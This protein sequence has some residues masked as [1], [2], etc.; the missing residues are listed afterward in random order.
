MFARGGAA[1]PDGYRR[2]ARWARNEL[3]PEPGWRL[4]ALALVRSTKSERSLLMYQ[5]RD[6][7]GPLT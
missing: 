7:A 6:V 4:G 3:L 1:G 5:D 2:R